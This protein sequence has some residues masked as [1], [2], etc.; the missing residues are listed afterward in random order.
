MVGIVS[1]YAALGLRP[2]ADA[3]SI[4]RAYRHLIKKYH[5][6]R[7]GGDA[8]RAAEI[9]QAYREIRR[10]RTL[11]DPLDFNEEFPAPRD[12]AGGLMFF[13]IAALALLGALLL[14]SGEGRAFLDEVLPGTAPQLPLA[15]KQDGGRPADPMDEPLDY[16][17]IDDAIREAA[18]LTQNKDEI[19]LAARSQGCHDQLRARPTTKQLDRCA[20]F[21]DAVVQLQNR[22]PFRDR[23]PFSALSVTRRQ[24]AAA[25]QI[26]EDYLAIDTRLSR[27]GLRVE[28]ALAPQSRGE[29]VNAN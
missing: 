21:D 24:W 22:D 4:D 26:S 3:E 19:T 8:A 13:L 23:G 7:A 15:E 16:N 12:K 18:W 29:V 1:A 11:E 27:I 9:N 5:P 6:D 28:L 25:S 2:G 10:S 14:V 17:V 20:A